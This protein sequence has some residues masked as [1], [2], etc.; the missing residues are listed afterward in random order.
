MKFNPNKIYKEILVLPDIHAPWAD[1]DAVKFAH[2]WYTKRKDKSSILVIQLGDLTDQKIWS[3]WQSDTDDFS[4]CQEFEE[5]EKQLKKL[6]KMFPNM[7]ILRGNHDDR[8]KSRAVEAGIPGKMFKDVDSVFN[9]KGWQ[10][11][12]R[13]ERLVVQTAR[14]PILFVH[15][16]EQGG[17]V[18]Q[19]SR[20]LGHS[21][22]Q[23]HTHKVSIT[24]TNQVNGRHIFGAEMGCLMDVQSKA[25]RYAQANPVGV[26]VGFGVVKHGVPY[27]IPYFKGDK[28]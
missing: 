15:G 28:V 22:I 3:R 19:K 1:W 9:Y 6:H 10:W 18:V 17:T 23:G 14:G 20:I 13:N 16:D 26:S 27:F 21:V 5:A 11:I 2:K 8:I 12:P 24:Y 25:G 4:P 7:L